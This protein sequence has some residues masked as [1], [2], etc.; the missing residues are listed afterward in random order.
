MVDSVSVVVADER[1]CGVVAD[2]MVVPDAG[3]EGEEPL[4]DA[5]SE[6]GEGAG[7]VSFERE[8]VLAAPDDRFD[9]LADAAEVAVPLGLVAA[10]GAQQAAAQLEA[11]LLELGAGEAFVGAGP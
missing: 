1:A 8:L 5:G 4:S 2:A 10:V 11:E 9:P 3:G 7:A 6:T